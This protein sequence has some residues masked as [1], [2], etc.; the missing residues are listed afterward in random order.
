MPLT[1]LTIRI[2]SD[3]VAHF[4]PGSQS[5]ERV[6][7]GEIAGA[8]VGGLAVI[9]VLAGILLYRHRR[10]R[11]VGERASGNGSSDSNSV[12]PFVTTA[13]T[14]TET[15]GPT[16]TWMSISN[17]NTSG[18]LVTKERLI[19]NAG[20]ASGRETN[21]DKM[22]DRHVEEADPQ[23]SMSSGHHEEGRSTQEQGGGGGEME[24]VELR[25]E[26]AML[27]GDMQQMAILVG[28]GLP[29]EY[30]SV[31]SSVN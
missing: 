24:I 13:D 28:P 14:M 29:P 9:I 30:R 26:I 3:S 16:K 1:S 11:S 4:G 12:L 22:N 27:R 17:S 20:D 31:H 7:T 5:R 2:H 18:S 23:P 21:H 19:D 10:R 15:M 25:R 6:S 8:V